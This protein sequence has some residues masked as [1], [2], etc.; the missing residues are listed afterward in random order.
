MHW[1]SMKR[2]CIRNILELARFVLLVFF[3]FCIYVLR[4]CACLFVFVAVCICFPTFVSFV[5]ACKIM[6]QRA[7]CTDQFARNQNTRWFATQKH[8]LEKIAVNCIH[9]ILLVH[10]ERFLPKCAAARVQCSHV[11]LAAVSTK[12]KT[13]K[14]EYLRWW[15]VSNHRIVVWWL[16]M[17]W[18]V[19]HFVHTYRELKTFSAHHR[20]NSTRV[21]SEQSRAHFNKLLILNV[22]L[23]NSLQFLLL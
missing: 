6:R 17:L 23:E 8:T 9:N 1:S 13:N 4:L 3:F 5:V 18:R 21:I 10:V 20:R 12:S 19:S 16:V 14:T 22:S 11:F 7:Y 15:V 2:A